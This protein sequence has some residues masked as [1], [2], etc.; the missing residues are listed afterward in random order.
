MAKM[1]RFL[2]VGLL[3]IVAAVTT[4]IGGANATVLHA[5]VA[6]LDD[7]ASAGTCGCSASADAQNGNPACSCTL[8]G[9]TGFP[10]GCGCAVELVGTAKMVHCHCA[11]STAG[12]VDTWCSQDGTGSNKPPVKRVDDIVQWY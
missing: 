11:C 4:A 3:P 2:T 10:S 8:T 12:S 9:G 7:S 6:V 5:R 1:R